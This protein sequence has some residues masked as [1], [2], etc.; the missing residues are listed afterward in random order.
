[1]NPIFN[2]LKKC[3]KVFYKKPKFLNVENLQELPTIF[4]SN[5]AQIHGPLV[6]ELYMPYKNYTW[7]TGEALSIKEFKSYAYKDF[8]SNKSKPIRWFYKGFSYAISP[9]AVWLFKRARVI[10]VYKDF[11]IV[12]TYR[13][14]ISK[15]EKGS[16]I[17]IFP[18]NREKCNL[19]INEFQKNFVDIARLYYKKAKKCISFTPMYI[20]PTIKT[21]VFGKPIT[22]DNKDDF[23]LQKEKIINHLKDEITSIALNL[24]PHAI[25][26][27][28][29]IARKFYKQSK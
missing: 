9:F 10:G 16:N 1:M 17:V 6:S 29:N 12:K 2:L 5:H 26:P 7:I 20:A 25:T 8:W 24:P 23:S 3:T 22:F 19:F 4:V 15:L 21:V 28:E 11:K 13:E 27:Y 14:T 18:E